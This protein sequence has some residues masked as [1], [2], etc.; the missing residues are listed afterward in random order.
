MSSLKHEAE[1]WSTKVTLWRGVG[2]LS[3][4]Q[5]KVVTNQNWI[6]PLME[7]V[8]AATLDATA[9]RAVSKRG[10]IQIGGLTVG[11]RGLSKHAVS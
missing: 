5:L 11:L 8:E 2:A 10:S 6:R 4:R 3:R 1:D 7:D 9:N